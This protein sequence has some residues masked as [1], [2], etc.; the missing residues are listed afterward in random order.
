[1][2]EKFNL[3]PLHIT[4]DKRLKSMRIIAIINQEGRGKEGIKN[5]EKYSTKNKK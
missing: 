5:I 3:P 2:R 1:M 4:A